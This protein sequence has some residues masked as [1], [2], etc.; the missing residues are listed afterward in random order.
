MRW[1]FLRGVR[2]MILIL[3]HPEVGDWVYCA[4]TNFNSSTFW[5][6]TIV[7]FV[8]HFFYKQLKMIHAK[9]LHQHFIFCVSTKL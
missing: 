9:M 2:H 5:L 8:S 7:F 1:V 4:D 3:I 6:V